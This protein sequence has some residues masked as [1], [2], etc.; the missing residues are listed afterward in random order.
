MLYRGGR[1]QQVIFYTAH[2]DDTQRMFFTTLLLEEVLSWTRKQPGTTGLR[3]LV[4][5]DEV[6][7][8]LPPSTHLVVR[9]DRASETDFVDASYDEKNED[10]QMLLFP[11]YFTSFLI[12]DE[13]AD[14]G[15]A[16]RGPVLI[17]SASSKTAIGVAYLLAQRDA[18]PRADLHPT[19]EWQVGEIV[20]DLHG[21]R[22][23]ANLRPQTIHIA[24]GLYNVQTNERMPV[25]TPDGQ[26]LP[27]DQFILAGLSVQ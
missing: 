8:Y 7:G 15:L 1:P 3:A 24:L 21:V 27:D 11:L 23:P 26:A 10:Q 4:Y 18:E 17:S 12:D 2:L 14:E 22:L 9:P 25:R 5:F 16:S 20:S 6:F 19:S 13:L